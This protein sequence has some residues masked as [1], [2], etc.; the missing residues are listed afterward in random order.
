MPFLGRDWRSPGDQWVRTTEGWEKLKL[1]RVKVFENLNQNV[2][3]RLI[4]LALLDIKSDQDNIYGRRQPYILY[5]RAMTREK[6]ELT[7]LSEALIRLDVAGAVKDIQ[8]INFVAKLL[9]LIFNKKFTGLSGTAQKHVISILEAFSNEVLKTEYNTGCI[10]D[11]LK[12][13]NSALNQGENSHIG[14]AC[15]WTRHKKAVAQM[16]D[17]ISEFQVKQRNDDGKTKFTDLP[18][19]CVRCIL[20]RIVDHKDIMRAGMSS[21]SLHLISQ[22]HWLWQQL[23]FFHFD[24]NQIL[25]FLPEHLEEKDIDWQYIYKRCYKR[26]GK[27]DLYADYLALCSCCGSIYW[28]SLG[29]PCVHEESISRNLS[30]QDFINLFSL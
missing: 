30:P 25:V 20:S 19:D 18:E 7:C 14:S 27:K 12:S 15:L 9:E 22:E 28:Q 26:F 21:T 8:R 1:W 24:D 3:A 4:R 23:C 6:K 2:I 16:Q 10:R 11:L 17:K 29:H 13:A 5:N